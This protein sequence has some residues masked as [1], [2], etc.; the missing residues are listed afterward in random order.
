MGRVRSF[1]VLLEFVRLIP[2]DKL[3][4]DFP[5]LFHR[6]TEDNEAEEVPMPEAT[7]R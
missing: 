3:P 1:T 7:H 5:S 2:I 6:Q 4:D